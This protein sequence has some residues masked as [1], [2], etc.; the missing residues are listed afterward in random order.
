MAAHQLLQVGREAEE[1]YAQAAVHI[2]LE[3][4]VD[5]QCILDSVQ[6]A[7]SILVISTCLT[8]SMGFTS[9]PS[10]F[11]GRVQIEESPPTRDQGRGL[12]FRD[13]KG[14]DLPK[15]PGYGAVAA[16][17]VSVQ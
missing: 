14:F 4:V 15:K 13:D 16:L 10:V 17:E 8:T 7:P 3:L 9:K 12:L 5:D 2:D 11:L 1:L 6:A